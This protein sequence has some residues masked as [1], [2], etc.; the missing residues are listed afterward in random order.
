MWQKIFRVLILYEFVVFHTIGQNVLTQKLVSTKSRCFQPQG[1]PWRNDAK[2][3]H[4]RFGWY[5]LG[6]KNKACA[7]PRLASFGG[8]R[9]TRFQRGAYAIVYHVSRQSGTDSLLINWSTTGRSQGSGGRNWIEIWSHTRNDLVLVL[10]SKDPDSI[11]ALIGE[12]VMFWNEGTK[13]NHYATDI[14]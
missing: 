12:G 9:V 4:V 6:F 10:L 5:H 7:T 13:W 3:R 14:C 1:C 2:R 11:G 8:L